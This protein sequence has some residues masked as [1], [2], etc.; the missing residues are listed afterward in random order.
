MKPVWYFL[1]LL[2]LMGGVDASSAQTLSYEN[3]IQQ[4]AVSC[5]TDIEKYCRGVE[6][7]GGRIKACLDANPIS[8]QCQQAQTRVYASI[9]RK[10]AAQ[11]DI[12]KI[13]NRDIDRFCGSVV[14]GDANILSC[15]KG[16]K[17]SLISQQCNQAFTDTGWRT[18]RVQQ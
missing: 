1:A 17:P 4:L 14:A 9:A 8:A 10:V 5:G 18:E 15:M 13:C 2:V 12:V 11:R 7:G 3:A 16:I 6:L